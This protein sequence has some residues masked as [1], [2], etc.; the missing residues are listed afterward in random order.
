MP[1][2][3]VRLHRNRKRPRRLIR[4]HFPNKCSNT[5]KVKSATLY[6]FPSTAANLYVSLIPFDTQSTAW[7]LFAWCHSLLRAPQ[8]KPA[9]QYTKTFPA[10]LVTFIWYDFALNTN[11]SSSSVKMLFLA[12]T[13]KKKKFKSDRERTWAVVGRFVNRQRMK[14][15]IWII[16]Y[17]SCRRSRSLGLLFLLVYHVYTGCAEGGLGVA[18][19]FGWKILLCLLNFVESYWIHEKQKFL[20]KFKRFMIHAN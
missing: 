13:R 4:Q 10:T 11:T 16:M 5:E 3:S 17:E 1:N 18:N 6:H 15:F 14:I 12:K 20:W 19:R 2:F 9:S 7:T 8:T